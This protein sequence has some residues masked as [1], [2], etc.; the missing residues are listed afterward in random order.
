MRATRG[1]D[2]VELGASVRG[3]SPSSALRGPGR[4]STGGSYVVPEDV[5]E[6][7]GPV[8]AHRVLF[9]PAFLAAHRGEGW[10]AVVSELRHRC[11]EAA[12]RPAAP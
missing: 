7:F 3:S 6:L 10:G 5:E 12:P 9:T 1:I 8:I 11:F 4:S 2:V